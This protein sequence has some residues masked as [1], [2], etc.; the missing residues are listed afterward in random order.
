MDHL[1]PAGLAVNPVAL[2]SLAVQRVCV[3]LPA[4]TA[5]LLTL[6]C[7]RPLPAPGVNHNR[8][9]IVAGC[10]TAAR[11]HPGA[12]QLTHPPTIR[13]LLHVGAFG[14]VW[15]HH[16]AHVGHKVLLLTAEA[17]LNHRLLGYAGCCCAAGSGQAKAAAG[18]GSWGDRGVGACRKDLQTDR[19]H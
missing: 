6:V 3:K 18:C 12:A 19:V 14:K 16:F 5:L 1:V 15:V 4:P 2:V 8:A 11:A 13:Q 17:G 9:G 7:A 10:C